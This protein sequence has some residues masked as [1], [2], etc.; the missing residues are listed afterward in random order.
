MN[1]EKLIPILNIV[2][3]KQPVSAAQLYK[4]I[5][6]G[7]STIR[8]YLK[9]LIDANLLVTIG[10]G[11]AI[12]YL[13]A[14]QYELIA[15]VNLEEYFQ[16]EVDDRN[17][18]EQFDFL[19]IKEVLS[20][21][22]LFTQEEINRLNQ[23][24]SKYLNSINGIEDVIYKKRLDVLAIDLIWKS[25][26]IEGNT[27]SLLETEALIKQH[28]L[29]KGKSKS[30][31]IML[32]NHKKALDF[33]T[34]DLDYLKPLTV[35]K[36]IDIHTLL[37]ADLGINNNVRKRAVA[38]TGTNYKP[39]SFESQILEALEATVEL[40]NSKESVFEKALLL[41]C[42]LSYIQAFNDGN[43]RTARIVS[44]AILMNYK[45]CPL[46]FRTIKAVDYKKAMLLF[47]EQNNLSEMKKIFIDQYD[48]AVSK[49][50]DL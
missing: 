37:I 50:F 35:N 46:S 20:K 31:A 17:A 33:I 9:E 5:D 40:V 4:E 39:L 7:Q 2:R 38:I 43:K 6:L 45:H 22:K 13:I 27:Y 41:L 25:S 23:I 21:A 3:T 49:Y 32:L 15:P 30:D 8:K 12:Q 44:N 14:P 10:K 36:I 47:Y 24:Q 34:E 1:F 26:E 42:L 19:L 29:A 48:Y 18:K 28:E 16:K 11:K